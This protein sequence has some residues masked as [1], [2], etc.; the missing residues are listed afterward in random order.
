MGKLIVAVDQEQ[1]QRLDGLYERGLKNQVPDLRMI[2][3]DEIKQ[4]EPNCVVFI[5]FASF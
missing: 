2:R 3:G 4:I 1:A 5:Y